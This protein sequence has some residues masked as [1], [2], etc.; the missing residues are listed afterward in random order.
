M[1]DVNVNEHKRW[2]YLDAAA[3]EVGEGA[4]SAMRAMIRV[5]VGKRRDSIKRWICR[6]ADRRG[7]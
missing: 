2:I 5:V 3:P 7:R 1:R 4:D 6:R